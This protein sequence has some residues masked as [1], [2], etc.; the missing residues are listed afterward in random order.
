MGCSL[1]LHMLRMPAIRIRKKNLV[2]LSFRQVIKVSLNR[3]SRAFGQS[4]LSTMDPLG[5]SDFT[6]ATLKQ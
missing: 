5:Q 3:I 2:N 1:L 4:W 6:R